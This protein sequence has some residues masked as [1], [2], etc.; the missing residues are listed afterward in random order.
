MREQVGFDV[1]GELFHLLWVWVR[2]MLENQA[3][4]GKLE[5]VVIQG[6][7]ERMGRGGRKGRRVSSDRRERWELKDDMEK[8]GKRFVLMLSMY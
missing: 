7:P 4:L 5:S 3:P 8:K 2:V 6:A 1:R